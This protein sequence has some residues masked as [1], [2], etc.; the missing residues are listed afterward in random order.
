MDKR[1]TQLRQSMKFKRT[2]YVLICAF[3]T[4]YLFSIPSFSGRYPFNFISYFLMAFLSLTVILYYFL[5]MEFRFDFRVLLYPSFAIWAFIGTAI[6]SH[7]FRSYLTLILLSLSFVVFYYSF[8]CINNRKKILLL[9]YIALAAFSVYFLIIYFRQL[10]DFSSLTN[11]RLGDYFDNVNGVG[12]YFATA[13]TIGLFFAFF[14]S[15][16]IEILHLVPITLF[17]YLGVATGSRTFLVTFFVALISIIVFKFRKHKTIMLLSFISLIVVFLVLIN[18]PFMSSL[19]IRFEKSFIALFS[20]GTNYQEM[21]SVT[22][23]LWQKYGFY[24]GSKNILFGL[25]GNGFS[26][27]SGVGTYTHGNFA[28]VFCNFGAIGFALYHCVY[29]IAIADSFKNKLDYRYFALSI[30][31]M[32]LFRSFLGVDYYDKLVIYI[33]SLSLYYCH[34]TKAN[35]EFRAGTL[36][37]SGLKY[38]MYI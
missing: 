13:S 8:Q 17:F 20:E 4:S 15:K 18:M 10:I 27:F 7:E 1:I 23:V 3:Y 16:K 33:F 12:T 25:G 2:L 5:Y 22:R 31:I 9:S 11:V 34:P 30:L 38:E 28:E 19:K 36:L 21:S 14:R 35:G 24:L 37:G 29:F 26:M 32:L 6:Y